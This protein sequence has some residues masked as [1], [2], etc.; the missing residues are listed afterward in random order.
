MPRH[1][2]PIAQLRSR[3]NAMVEQFH[4][5]SIR[6][7]YQYPP[8][9]DGNPAPANQQPVSARSI[10]T[11]LLDPTDEWRRLALVHFYRLPDGQLSASGK[12]DPKWAY[13]DGV[14]YVK[15]D[16]DP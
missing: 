15:S 13:I 4:A 11:Y 10:V 16:A 12:P 14:I 8:L 9:R 7:E 1:P 2:L 5:N 6:L 3:F